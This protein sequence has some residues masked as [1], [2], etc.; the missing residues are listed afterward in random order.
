MDVGV[1]ILQV[2][3]GDYGSHLMQEQVTLPAPTISKKTKFES[4]AIDMTQQR[5]QFTKKEPLPRPER[6]AQTYTQ[7]KV[8][9]K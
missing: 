7:P 3:Q 5:F 9:A 6:K 4:E 8:S 1:D 2:D